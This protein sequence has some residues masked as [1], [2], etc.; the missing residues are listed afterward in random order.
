MGTYVPVRAPTGPAGPRKSLV[1]VRLRVYV[2]VPYKNRDQCPRSLA[3]NHCPR[4]VARTGTKGC[5]LVPVPST[6]RNQGF[7]HISLAGEQSN[8]LVLC[9]F[10]ECKGRALWCSS[11]PP[12][13]M[14]CSMKCPSHTT[15]S[16]LLSKLDL[17]ASFFSR[18]V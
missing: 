2:P 16:F 5:P 8:T 3:H 4:L 18:F 1:P 7:G 9:F 13:Q 12:M 10:V 15:Y 6:N 11:S 14:M 17:Q